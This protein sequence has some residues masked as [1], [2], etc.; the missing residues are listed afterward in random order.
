MSS[1]VPTS[2]FDQLLQPVADSLTPE[3]AQRLVDIRVDEATQARIDEL[4]DKCTEGELTDE[5]RSQY[6]SYVHAIEMIS[7]LQAKARQTLSHRDAS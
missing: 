1:T 2:I 3:V 7:L 5:E 4:A 6:E